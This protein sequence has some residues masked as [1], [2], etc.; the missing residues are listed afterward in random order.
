MRNQIVVFLFVT[1]KATGNKKCE[2][3]KCLCIIIQLLQIFN[4][5]FHNFPT[6][7]HKRFADSNSVDCSRIAR[8]LRS[9]DSLSC[10]SG[11][12]CSCTGRL[13]RDFRCWSTTTPLTSCSMMFR[14]RCENKIIINSTSQTI[15]K[16][17]FTSKISSCF[18]LSSPESS[19][20]TFAHLATP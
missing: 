16:S 1:S 9:S 8:S 7:F 10:C 2:H 11:S 17:K 15:F 3:S 18:P 19:A 12:G 20:A 6:D 14:V 5:N 13:N 4:M